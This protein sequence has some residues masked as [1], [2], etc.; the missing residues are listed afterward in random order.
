L[1]RHPCFF[2]TAADVLEDCCGFCPVP[3]TDEEI[4]VAKEENKLYISGKLTFIKDDPGRQEIGSFNPV[5]TDDWCEMAYV[6][7]TQMLCQAIVDGD[8][9]YVRSWCMQEGN[10]ANTRDYC[11]RTPLHLAVAASTTEVVQCIIDNGARLLAR[12]ADG[13][14]A[15][16]LAASNGNVEMVKVLMD[17]SLSNQEGEDIRVEKKKLAEKA[18]P[19]AADRKED[20]DEADRLKRSG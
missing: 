3:A 6:G 7:N 8:A 20:A 10:D 11:G 12:V 19:T 17:K 13:R 5:T 15:L 1:H 16:H 18:E 4:E 9:E 2:G 14:T